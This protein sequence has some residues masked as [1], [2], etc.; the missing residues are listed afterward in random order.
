V[1]NI[2]KVTVL[3][4]F[5]IQSFV[6][7]AAAQEFVP[8]EV[9]I[10]L[11]SSGSPEALANI[12]AP[13]A[14]SSA[15]LSKSAGNARLIRLGDGVTVTGAVAL[16]SRDQGVEY[17]EPNWI[18]HTTVGYYQ[19]YPETIY[20]WAWKKIQAYDAWDL[21]TGDSSIVVNIN[22]SGIDL[23]HE[24]LADNLWT[25][26][27]EATGIAGIDDDGNGYVDDIHG[28]NAVADNGIPDDD[29]F[30]GTHVAGTIGAVTKNKLGV[31][32]LNWASSILPCKFLS[33]HGY[34][35]I[36]DAIECIDYV[37]ATKNNVASNADVRVSNNSWAGAAY[38]HALKDAIQS[39]VDEDILWVNAAG[40]KASNKDCFQAAAYPS[41]YNIDGIIAVANTTRSDEIF[42][43]SDYGASTVDIGAPGTFIRSTWINNEYGILTGTSMATP[44]VAGVAALLLAR[45]PTMS[46]T[47]LREA[48]LCTGD[49]IPALEGKTRTGMRLNAVRAL[50]SAFGGG[51]CKDRDSDG[52]PDYAD[53]CPY[54][55]NDQADRDG[56]GVG[57]VCE[58]LDCGGGC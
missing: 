38:S 31:A 51:T 12:A 35:S 26:A 5:S 41:G 20:Q 3:L 11:K 58:P 15:P 34:G 42:K 56:N 22:D 25:N 48:I 14:M 2:F 4:F 16:L 19:L 52:V 55:L 24:D 17:A 53:N 18:L 23:D 30:H 10:K 7:S 9:I 40:N 54:Q 46:M 6:F 37:I 28:W 21:E 29:F 47:A 8:G 36:F 44:H 49:P 45:N 27:L 57:D 32:G 13:G 33:G 43:F 39:A 50:S 1:K